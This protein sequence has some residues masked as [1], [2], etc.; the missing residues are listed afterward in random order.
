MGFVFGRY[1]VFQLIKFDYLKKFSEIE[2]N[3]MRRDGH[4][5]T[6]KCL[7]EPDVVILFFIP[8]INAAIL[9]RAV[10]LV[11]ID[12]YACIIGVLLGRHEF[13][14][15]KTIQGSIGA[16]LCISITLFLF[17]PFPIIYV[18]FIALIG[19]IFEALS[20]KLILKD[21]FYLALVGVITFIIFSNITGALEIAID[22]T[23]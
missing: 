9:W 2:Q 4:K 22:P 12:V 20:P 16:L 6:W 8:F 15:E 10:L 11:L 19:I 7:L 5:H 18:L 21:N 1:L 14:E 13:L 17:T 3:F 23:L